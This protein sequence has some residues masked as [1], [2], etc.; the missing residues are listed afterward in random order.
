[1]AQAEGTSVVPLFRLVIK[2]CLY[3]F[4]AKGLQGNIS[5]ARFQVSTNV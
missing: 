4:R 3:P 5:E 2:V 1:V